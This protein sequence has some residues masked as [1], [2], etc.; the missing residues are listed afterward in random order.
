MA[1]ERLGSASGGSSSMSVTITAKKN[2]RVIFQQNTAVQCKIQ[3]NDE[4]GSEYSL[5]RSEDGGSDGIETSQTYMRNWNSGSATQRMTIMDIVNPSGKEKICIIQTVEST[6]GSSNAPNRMES[7]GK[8]A[9]TSGQI[10]KVSFVALSG[11]I[12]SN[13]TLTVLGAKE[14]ATANVMTVDG[15][16][17]KKNLRIEAYVK[18]GNGNSFRFNNDTGNNYAHRYSGNGGTDGTQTSRSDFW[19]YYDGN[20]TEKYTVIHVKNEASKEKLFI[21]ETSSAVGTGA[22]T[23]PSRNETTGKWANT[24]AQ[25]TRVDVKTYTTNGLEEGSEVVVWGSDGASDTTH[26]TVVNGF[27]LEETD[28]G[29]HYIWNATTSTWTEIV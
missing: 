16:T 8:F 10:T 23:A 14:P 25:I 11:T 9:V 5:R 27:I 20:D 18:G 26:P 21:T 28:T 7:V 15:F 4:T 12:D 24:S 1:W 3:F 17:A 29:K 22:G 6:S 19:S 13:A 2:L